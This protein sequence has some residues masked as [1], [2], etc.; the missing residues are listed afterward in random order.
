LIVLALEEDLPAGDI[1]TEAIVPASLETSA[2]FLAKEKGSA[3][4][5]ANCSQGSVGGR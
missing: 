1:T 2:I 4:W 5:S 3:G